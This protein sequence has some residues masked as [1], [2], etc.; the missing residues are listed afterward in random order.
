MAR[1]R[2]PGFVMTDE[3]RS[4]IANSQIL[5]RL[6]ACAEG[7]IEMTPTE[8]SVALGLMRKVMPDMATVEHSGSVSVIPAAQLS[9]DELAGIAAGGGEGA[10]DTS[11]DPSQLN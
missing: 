2:K 5:N 11:L 1:G 3:H 10:A 9:D 4:K 7:K 6:I 8:A